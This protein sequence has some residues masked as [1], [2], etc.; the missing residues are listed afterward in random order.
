LLDS[1]IAGTTTLSSDADVTLSTTTGAANTSREAI[2]LWTAGGTVTRNITAPAQSKAYIVINASSSTQSIVLRG[3]GP[4]TGVTIIKGEAAVCAWNGSDFIKVSNISGAG[5]FSSLTVTGTTTLSGLTASTALALDASKNAV[6]VTNTGTG[7]NVLATSPTITTPTISSLTSAAATALTLQSAGTTAVT[8]DTSQNVGIGTSS[9]V[10]KLNVTA[11]DAATAS[12]QVIISGGRSLGTGVYGSA[13]ALLFSNSYFTTGYGAASIAAI[14]SGASG[15]YLAFGT[16]TNGSGVTGTPTERMR[17]DSGGAVFI[18]A[19]SAGSFS[20]GARLSVLGVDGEFS[21]VFR[22]P[23]TG[24]YIVLS[25]DNP[26]GQVGKIQTS[27]SATSF[28]TSSDYRLKEDITP[29]T[30]AL[31][32]VA[33]LKPVTY[34]W[35]VDGTDGQGFIAHELQEVV[36]DCVGGEKDAVDANGNPQYQGVDTSFLVATLTAAIQEQQALITSLTARIAAL[37]GTP[38]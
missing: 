34:K 8:V 38:A 6:S 15:G 27:G 7:N 18:N 13:G 5:V 4:T 25:C 17:I 36:P 2:L 37:E 10:A 24:N 14:D 9:P 21:A 30:G 33:L 26:N 32:K 28:L 22:A 29:M 11:G 16:T 19:T 3:A 35:K 20:A 23:T 31:A 12:N 1:A